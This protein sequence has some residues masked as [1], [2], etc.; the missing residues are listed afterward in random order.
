MDNGK[1]TN[2]F[3]LATKNDVYMKEHEE[4]KC[5]QV[6]AVDKTQYS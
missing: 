1:K 2:T 6:L 3:N 5:Q 4:A